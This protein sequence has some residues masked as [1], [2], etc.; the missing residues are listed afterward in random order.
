MRGQKLKANTAFYR[1][2]IRTRIKTSGHQGINA[3]M[4][5]FYRHSIRTRIKTLPLR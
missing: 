3:A 4:A 5:L 2:S 1:H